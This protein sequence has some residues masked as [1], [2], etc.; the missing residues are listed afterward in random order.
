MSEDISSYQEFRT[1]TGITSS[2]MP[3]PVPIAKPV[4]EEVIGDQEFEEKA[5]K[6]VRY[7]WR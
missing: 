2:H 3:L 6:L 1:G 7:K 5:T 4:D